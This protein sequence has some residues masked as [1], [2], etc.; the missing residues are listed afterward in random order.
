MTL[1]FSLLFNFL[2]HQ[3]Y[4]QEMRTHMN[5]VACRFSG[6]GTHPVL[7][8]QVCTRYQVCQVPGTRYKYQVQVP[9][10]CFSFVGTCG[11]SAC[12]YLVCRVQLLERVIR[13]FPTDL[14]FNGHNADRRI[15]ATPRTCS[16]SRHLLEA[17]FH[18]S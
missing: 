12:T 18:G 8:K 17:S 4:G 3:M 11:H 2:E 7:G 1:P 9:F 14:N 15:L 13:H 16:S 6:S 10:C 5:V